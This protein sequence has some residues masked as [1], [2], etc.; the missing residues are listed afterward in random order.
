MRKLQ[1]SLQEQLHL[2][3]KKNRLLGSLRYNLKLKKTLFPPKVFVKSFGVKL[4]YRAIELVVEKPNTLMER[5]F[6]TEESH[7]SL[8]WK[9]NFYKIM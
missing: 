7:K 1:Q 6:L 2:I 9:Q 3:L 8:E 5:K 4:V